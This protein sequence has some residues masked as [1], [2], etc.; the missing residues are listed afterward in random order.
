LRAQVKLAE[1]IETGLHVA[2]KILN[3]NRVTSSEMKDKVRGAQALYAALGFIAL[4]DFIRKHGFDAGFGCVCFDCVCFDC[5]RFNCV[6]SMY[7][8]AHMKRA[9][10]RWQSNAPFSADDARDFHPSLVFPPS[11][12]PSIRNN[13]NPHRNIP[14]HGVRGCCSTQSPVPLSQPSTV[15]LF[16]HHS[17][18]AV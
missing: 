7:S 4:V 3:M 1:H 6:I 5:V 11:R 9:Y 12:Y 18:Q 10:F 8:T 15:A 16:P 13:Y 14:R 2:I 17:R